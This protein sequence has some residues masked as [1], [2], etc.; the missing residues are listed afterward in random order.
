MQ[1]HPVDESL[2]MTQGAGMIR[3]ALVCVLAVVACAPRPPDEGPVGAD[4]GVVVGESEAELALEHPA[5]L[6]IVVM[7][8]RT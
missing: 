2:G 3:G 7:D 4:S 1:V 6:G 5:D 8:F